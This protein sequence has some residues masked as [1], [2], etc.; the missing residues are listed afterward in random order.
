MPVQNISDDTPFNTEKILYVHR[1]MDID[2]WN[3][4]H[5][6]ESGV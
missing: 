1:K 4:M 3:N 2:I 6:S 5:D